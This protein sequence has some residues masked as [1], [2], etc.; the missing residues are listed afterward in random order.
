MMEDLPAKLMIDVVGGS[1]VDVLVA[2]L[3]QWPRN[4]FLTV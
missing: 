4:L 2:G 3:L 1:G